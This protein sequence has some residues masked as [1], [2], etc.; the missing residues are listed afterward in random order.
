MRPDT[1]AKSGTE[2][3]HQA[4]LFCFVAVV[5]LLGFEQA[6]AWADGKDVKIDPTAEEV[7]PDLA[8]YHAIPNGANYG[9]DERGSRITGGKMKA[10][11]LR[12]GVLDTLLPVRR[13]W[14][15]GLYIEMKK[16][17]LKSKKDAWNGM[18]DEQKEF[19]K[20]VQSQSFIVE[21]CYTWREAAQ[22]LQRY[23]EWK[24]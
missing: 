1:I 18:S 17:T 9:D 11:G 5:R 4:A 24:P 16:P 2:H 12:K 3:G 15:S 13:V 14:A 7:V 21:V 6:W 20:F 19:A 23:L 10:E 8:W 22:I